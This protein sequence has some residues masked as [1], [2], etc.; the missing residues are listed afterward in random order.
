MKR[1]LLQVRMK[2]AHLLG[3]LGPVACLLTGGDVLRAQAGFTP[4]VVVSSE[5]TAEPK[6]DI[7]PGGLL[8]INAPARLAVRVDRRNG[9][10]SITT[11]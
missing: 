2:L 10:W 3:L 7:A 1:R 6:I 5:D 9:T 8:Y 4:P 11:D